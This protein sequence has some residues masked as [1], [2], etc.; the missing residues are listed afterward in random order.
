MAV[1]VTVTVTVTVIVREISHLLTT[2]R[3]IPLYSMISVWIL[4]SSRRNAPHP[5]I[6]LLPTNVFLYECLLIPELQQVRN[7]GADS[8]SPLTSDGCTATPQDLHRSGS[9]SL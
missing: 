3:I 4:A 5:L 2:Y 6:V 9:H 7:L 1:T 8:M